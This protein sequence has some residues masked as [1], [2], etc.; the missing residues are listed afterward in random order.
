M[1]SFWA[2]I[3]NKGQT[4]FILNRVFDVQRFWVALQI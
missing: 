3:G 1:G 2:N 4:P